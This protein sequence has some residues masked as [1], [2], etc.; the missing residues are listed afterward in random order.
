MKELQAS[1]ESANDKMLRLSV[2]TGGCSGFQYVFDLDN[3][4]TSDDRYTD[5]FLLTCFWF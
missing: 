5:A 2:E 4:T 1:E 3:K